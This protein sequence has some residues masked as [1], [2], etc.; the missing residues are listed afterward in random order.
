MSRPSTWRQLELVG[1]AF[2]N[3]S[4]DERYGKFCDTLTGQLRRI[5]LSLD[6]ETEFVSCLIPAKATATRGASEDLVARER[7][8]RVLEFELC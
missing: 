4:F 3:Q 2:K 7:K 6:E 5:W 1:L 8:M